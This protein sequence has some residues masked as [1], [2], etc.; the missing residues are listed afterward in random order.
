MDLEEK[1]MIRNA[2]TRKLMQTSETSIIK[3][4]VKVIMVSL[5]TQKHRSKRISK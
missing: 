4:E 1:L 3:S 5:A 2:G